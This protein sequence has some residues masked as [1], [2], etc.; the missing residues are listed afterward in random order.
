[1]YIKR[2]LLLVFFFLAAVLI[3][4]TGP[5]FQ[6]SIDFVQAES[7]TITVCSS[8]C[9]ATTIQAGIDMAQPGDIVL[10]YP[11]TYSGGLT[12]GKAVTL[13]STF[14]TTQDPNNITSTVINSGAPIINVTSAGTGAKVIGFTFTGGTKGY[15]TFAENTE[16][17]DNRFIDV[18]DDKISWENVGGIIR[19]NYLERGGD[20]CIDLDAPRSGYVEDNT[21]INTSDDGIEIRMNNYTGLARE[22]YIRGNKITG[23]KEDAIQLIDYDQ[24]TQYRI[25]IERNILAN[26]LD[27]GIGIMDGGLTVEDYRGAMIPERVHV[28]NNTIVGN[29]YGITGGGNLAAV[30]NIVANNSLTGMKNVSIDSQASFNLFWAN[31]TNYTNSNVDTATTVIADPLLD[32]NY[33]LVPGSPGIDT[34]TATFVFRGETILNLQLG[35]Y[36][37]VAPDIGRYENGL[38]ASPTPTLTPTGQIASPT[39]TPTPVG[40]TTTVVSQILSG[41]DDAEQNESSGSMSLSSSDLE[42]TMDGSTKQT[43]GMRFTALNIPQNASITDAY[44]EFTADETQ[45]DITDLNFYT[46]NSDNPPNFASTSF[47]ISSR[48]KTT[49][50]VVWSDIN[51]WTVGVKYKTPNLAPVI[52]EI[53]NRPGWTSGNAMVFIVTGTGHRTAEAFE[54]GSAIAAKLFV[55]YSTGPTPTSIPTPTVDPNAPTSTPTPTPAPTSTP[56]ST[57]TPTPTIPPTPTYTPTPTSAPSTSQSFL[58]V[59]DTFVENTRATSNFGSSTSL[60]IDGNPIDITY[61]RFDLTPLAGK[62]VTSAILRVKVTSS[63]NSTQLVKDVADISWNELG[64]NYNTRPAMGSIFA[65]ITGAKTGT[66]K[67]IDLTSYIS[68]KAGSVFSLGIDSTG[69]DGLR[70]YSKERSILSDRPV[71]IVN[72]Q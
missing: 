30:N 29:L 55:T 1:M 26:S 43:L 48:A 3:K 53:V 51:V 61:M 8:G 40:P 17:L 71:L 22:I 31:G 62:T 59:A 37:G 7:G 6:N 45:P 11:G 47:N 13:A 68:S 38:T 57:P 34:G 39:P 15:V 19:R 14:Y 66:Y 24:S 35:E 72:F 41:T 21:C 69:S 25:Y 49:T 18:N 52:Q 54:A 56:T 27:V 28:I 60:T 16:L 67:D 20:D 58:P 64:I 32:V 5:R 70:F 12:I 42:F 2:V 23:A 50:S 65:N 46:Q 9:N 10:V 36:I 4:N 44:I 33:Q 63:S